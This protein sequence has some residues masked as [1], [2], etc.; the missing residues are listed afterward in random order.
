ME[1]FSFT[2]GILLVVALIMV[3]VLILGMVKVVNLQKGFERFKQSY[4][5]DRED[6]YRDLG[7]RNRKINN[8]FGDVYRTLDESRKDAERYIDRRI[9][10][11][12]NHATVLSAPSRPNTSLQLCRKDFRDANDGD[13]S[14]FLQ[15]ERDRSR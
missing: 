14:S 6:M 12:I 13:G 8:E 4:N 10:K 7:D 5:L 2:L 3:G 9:D 1:I 11:S 15:S